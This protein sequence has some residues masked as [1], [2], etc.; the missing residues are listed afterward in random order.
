MSSSNNEV[1]VQQELKKII[2]NH[3]VNNPIF[4]SELCKVLCEKTGNNNLGIICEHII[5][6]QLSH[7]PR[8]VT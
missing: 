5:D 7:K 8:I 4:R 1:E 6:E 2:K 3:Y